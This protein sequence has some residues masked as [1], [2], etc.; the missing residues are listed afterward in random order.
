VDHGLPPWADLALAN[1]PDL[2][3]LHND[4]QFAAILS[5]AKARGA[6]K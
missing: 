2:K 5:D 3:S 1:D 4:P 6:Q